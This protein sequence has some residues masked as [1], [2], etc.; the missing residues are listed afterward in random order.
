MEL[1]DFISETLTQIIQGVEEA[2][3]NT[4]DSGGFISPYVR[5]TFEAKHM[6][7]VTTDQTPVHLVNFDV[8]LEATDGT[9]TKGGIGVVTGLLSAGSQGQSNKS[10]LASHKIS[11][12]I[13]ISLPVVKTKKAN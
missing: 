4:K 2:Q 6:V 8:S 11:F 7:A 5:T 13:P 9:G 10:N 12:N 1:K 3:L